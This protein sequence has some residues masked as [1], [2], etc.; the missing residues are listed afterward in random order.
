[1]DKIYINQEITD[2]VINKYGEIGLDQIISGKKLLFI[3]EE[4]IKLIT[5][6]SVEISIP[7]NEHDEPFNN[8]RFDLKYLLSKVKTNTV[9]FKNGKLKIR[10]RS[11]KLYFQYLRS[12]IKYIYLKHVLKLTIIPNYKIPI[13]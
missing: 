13:K 4:L 6:S 7:V 5:S 9:R 1:M 11:L 10:L 2:Y 3:D 8:I 12:Y